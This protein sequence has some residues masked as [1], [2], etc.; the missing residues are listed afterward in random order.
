MKFSTIFF[1]W[2]DTLAPL[3][4]SGIPILNTWVPEMIQKLYLN[5]YR[6][7]IISNTYRYQDGYWIRNELAKR[8]ILQYFEVIVP[9]STY[10]IH[11]PDLAIF[12]KTID[13][14]QV[15]PSQILM[16]GDSQ[17][18]DG[19]IQYLKAKYLLVNPKDNWAHQLY[20]LLEDKLNCCRKL[21]P[22]FEFKL[23]NNVLITTKRHLSEPLNPGDIFLVNQD[24]Y[25]VID[26]PK[27]TKPEILNAKNEFIEI[28][29]KK[30]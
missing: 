27:I 28:I 10:A 5:S 17:K 4:H 1:D 19:A 20:N 30:V 21:T 29:V 26:A 15:N 22:L 12:Q 6:L 24:E 18:C 2:G 16:V 7:A 3:D 11:K 25:K 13:F 23:H 8:N 14:M 9:S